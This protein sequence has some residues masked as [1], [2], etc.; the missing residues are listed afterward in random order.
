MAG[1]AKKRKVDNLMALAVFATVYQRPMHRYEMASAMR[2]YGKDRD[3]DIKWGSLYTV[4]RN[5]EKH[6]F[7]E[8]V[9]SDRQGSRPERTIY[10]ITEL[11][12]QEMRDWT[13]DLLSTP[14]QEHPAFAA[15]L[16]VMSGVPPREV[17]ALLT[18]R[19]AALEADLAVR[20]AD[21]AAAPPELPA[22]FLIEE[23]YRMA[24]LSAEIA[25][26]RS[27]V[28]QLAAGSY[29]GQDAWQAFHDTGELSPELKALA[30]KGVSPKDD[31]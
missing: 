22:I 29:P 17:A 10:Q 30:E 14:S 3:M 23:E 21:M 8:A 25:W 11:G 7:L 5:M 19:L 6:G 31:A 26:V 15:G 16:S 9:G 13:R 24:M 18:T 28:G 20:R 27:L 12:K 4:V 2:A 1:K